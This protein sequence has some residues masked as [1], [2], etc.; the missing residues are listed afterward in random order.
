[1]S[2]VVLEVIALILERVEGLVLYLPATTSG[3]HHPFDRARRKR[4]V[5][6]PCPAR[7]AACGVRLLI[8]QIVDFDIRRALAQAQAARPRKVML[9]TRGVGLPQFAD[10]PALKSP[11]ELSAEAAVRVRL[12]VQDTR[13]SRSR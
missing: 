12:D 7:D 13:S 8:E 11:G 1:M 2:V 4:Q 6:A 3:S 10:L 9:Q 5:G